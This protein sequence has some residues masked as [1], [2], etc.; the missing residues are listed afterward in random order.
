MDK[1]TGMEL[2]TFQLLFSIEES[3][4]L[5]RVMAL[6]NTSTLMALTIEATGKMIIR[7]G[8]VF[9]QLKKENGFRVNG[10]T[11]EEKDQEFIKRMVITL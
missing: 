8:L 7:M 11:I 6:E 4:S 3:F 1:F 2:L 10:L 5:A 9:G